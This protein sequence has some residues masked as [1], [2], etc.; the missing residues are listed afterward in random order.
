MLKMTI[1]VDTRQAEAYLKRLAGPQG[2]R[3]AI[4]RALNRT[5]TTV[6]DR[7]ARE[8]YA[9]RNLKLSTI[10]QGIEIRRATTNRLAAMI[11][12][13][14]QPISIRHF[15][16]VN[17]RSITAKV[18]RTGPRVL[19]RANGNKAFTNPRLGAGVTIFVREGRKRLPIKAW[20]KVSGIASVFSQQ[21]LERLMREVAATTFQQRLRHEL[22]W[23][24]ER[25][26]R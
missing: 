17:K 23:I 21:R 16:N 18:S 26:K 8:I 1:R 14:G 11:V 25:A 22:A 4:A 2:T 19:L 9:K 3:T 20:P 6:R 13:S 15:A 5:A 24:I 12:A 10:K 7:A